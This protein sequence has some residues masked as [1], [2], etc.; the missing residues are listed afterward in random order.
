MKLALIFLSLIVLSCS[1]SNPQK[2][3][4]REPAT[5][6]QQE[7][8]H[9]T[10]E[11]TAELQA[12]VNNQESA[13]VQ[14]LLAATR[15][16]QI[17][18]SSFDVRVQKI[19]SEADADKLFNSKL[20][21][22]LIE[23]RGLHKSVEEKLT[24]IFTAAHK[25]GPAAKNWFFNELVT[26]AKKDP[27]NEIAVIQVLRLLA[28]GEETYCGT[29]D[30]ITADVQTLQ[31]F[32][33]A[34]LDDEAVAAFTDRH[35]VTYGKVKKTDLETGACMKVVNI[36]KSIEKSLEIY[37]WK[38]RNWT[39]AILPQGQFIFTYDDGPHAVYSKQ[40][41][42]VWS[43][44]GMAKPAFFWLAKNARMQPG[45]VKEL[46]SQGYAIA[47][48]SDD[49]ADIGNLAR[50]ATAA[51]LNSASRSV[52]SGELKN[53]SASEYPAWKAR[54][55]DRE[56]NQ[57]IAAISS[58]TGKRVPYF[59]LPYGSG[60]NHPGIG[61]RFQELNVDHFF[62]RV[63]S[64]DWQDKNAVSIRNRVVGQMK[65]MGRGIILFHDIHPQ[66]VKA[67]QMIVDF[68]KANPSY[69]AV[70][71]QSLPGVAK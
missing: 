9:L 51:D 31:G 53:V 45:I 40:I 63:D 16:A 27:M 58:M 22:K 4:P 60:V 66:S 71:I 30:C 48:H 41:R 68:M 11:E 57:S 26:F 54:T 61:R 56:I 47:S 67:S 2:E 24:T 13:R 18:V 5:Y 65:A 10:P 33:V 64:L 1:H 59:R 23:A 25:N 17:L 7:E 14:H 43:S 69:K 44:A 55:M 37:D 36:D 39:G 34:P 12:V 70:P 50:S 20:Y 32:Q 62:W 15:V 49:H 38:N 28:Q 6:A 8:S 42:D 35:K 29:K 21:C 3:V 52:F 46:A 19:K